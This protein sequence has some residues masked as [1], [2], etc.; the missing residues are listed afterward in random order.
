[1]RLSDYIARWRHTRGYGVHSP[2]AYR[3]VKECVRPDSRYGFYSD[4]FIDYE[5]RNDRKRCRNVRM[6]IRFV[7]LLNPGRVWIPGC[8]NRIKT[9]LILSFPHLQ[10]TTHKD[11]PKGVE[12]IVDFGGNKLMSLWNKFDP[13]SECELLSFSQIKNDELSEIENAPT[14]KLEGKGYTILLRRR[15]MDNISYTLI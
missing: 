15:G 11:C 5:F 1:M 13:Y 4:A 12:M 7:N 9:A 14:L 3:I 10:L 8:D 6:L 2:I